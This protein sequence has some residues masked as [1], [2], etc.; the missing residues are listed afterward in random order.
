[1][2]I[3]AF[4]GV[5]ISW[6]MLARKADL[7]A[8]GRLGGL[9]GPQQ[10]LGGLL[11]LGD[12]DRHAVRDRAAVWRAPRAGAKVDPAQL[13]VGQPVAQLGGENAHVPA[14]TLSSAAHMR[15]RSSATRVLKIVAASA[16]PAAA[17]TPQI[18]STPLLR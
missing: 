17:V 5:R 13:A 16:S 4:S 8:V 1:M 14:R 9:L 6:L 7:A 18:R 2:P 15:A 10:L 11:A 3:T 12:V